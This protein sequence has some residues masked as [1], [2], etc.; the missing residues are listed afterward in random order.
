[1][2]KFFAAF[3]K[4]RSLKGPSFFLFWIG[5][6]GTL[7]FASGL[8][9]DFVWVDHIEIEQGGYRLT[10]PGDWADLWTL[11]LDQYLERREGAPDSRGGYWRPVYALSLSLDWALWQDQAFFYHLENI[12][13][14][15]LV[16]WGLFL[17]GDRLLVGQAGGRSAVFWATM[18]F[19]VHP[20]G[21]HSVTWISGRKDT[22][23]AAFAV[24][25][26]LV[27]GRLGAAGSDTKRPTG[28]DGQSEERFGMSALLGRTVLGLTLLD[29]IL[30]ALTLLS[31]ALAL[32]SKELAMVVPLVAFLLLWPRWARDKDRPFIPTALGI[33]LMWALVGV[34]ALYRL[35]FL[36]GFGLNAQYPATSVA[37]NVATGATLFW[38]YIFQVLLPWDNTISDA[39]PIARDLG[40]GEALAVLGLVAALVVVVWGA[41]HRRVWALPLLWYLVWTLPASGI[42][43]LRH[44]RAERYLYPA[45]WGLLLFVALVLPPLWARIKIGER[46]RRLGTWVPAVLVVMLVLVSGYRSSGWWD[47]A[48]LFGRSVRSDPRH[49]EAWMALALDRLEAGDYAR[50]MDH[51]RRA[52][53]VGQDSTNAVY[54][55]PFVAYTNLGLAQYHAGQTAEAAQSFLVA[56]KRRPH[57]ATAHYHAGLAAFAQGLFEQAKGHYKRCLALKPDDFLCRSN[58]ALTLMRLGDLGRAVTLLQPLVDQRPEDGL[59]RTNLASALLAQGVFS[60]AEA[61]FFHLVRQEP[62]QPLH[63][64]K[65]AWCQWENGKADQARD[66]F[67]R[68]RRR[69]GSHP[70]VVHV[71]KVL[72]EAP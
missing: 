24:G 62:D 49:A 19:A 9:G 50:A 41:L 55:A 67:S 64:L 30:L 53:K 17:L 56:L 68:A 40:L 61:H 13:W 72:G 15:L 2:N 35:L 38:H 20:L 44:L 70:A 7:A 47:D 11:T 6:A 65:L 42:L 45:S 26:L 34:V 3:I 33:A 32:L 43:P 63:R 57:N 23:C 27:L 14:H 58:L 66:N 39:W 5:V 21:M 52:I 10:G 36:G 31:L 37:A 28:T 46:L 51:S 12:V 1:M 54:W 60:K 4:G 18:L 8:P 22:M 16:C 29:L 59:N 69:L 48:T 71:G 25:A